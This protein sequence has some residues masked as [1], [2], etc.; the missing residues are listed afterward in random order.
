MGWKSEGRKQGW[1]AESSV[2]A[3]HFPFAYTS[4]SLSGERWRAEISPGKVRSLVI[5]RLQLKGPAADD[6]DDGRV[7]AR[8]AAMRAVAPGG[9]GEGEYRI[10]RISAFRSAPLH[11]LLQAGTHT[12][13]KRD[14]TS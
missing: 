7:R 13:W 2:G 14:R 9:G 1:R 3:F 4:L 5:S 12:R 8:L 11:P 6:V 10:P